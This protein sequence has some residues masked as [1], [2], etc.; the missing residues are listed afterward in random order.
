MS[1]DDPESRESKSP[2]RQKH[3]PIQHIGLKVLSQPENAEVDIV[4]VHGI[5]AHPEKTWVSK[6]SNVN[7]LSHKT[8]L[9]DAIPNARI[10]AFGYASNWFGDGAVKLTL[11]GVARELLM[12]LGSARD[13]CKHRPIVFI[14]HCFGGLVIQQAYT[15]AALH[16][17]DENLF[18]IFDSVTGMVFLGTP[19]YGVHENF[20]RQMWEQI[21]IKTNEENLQVQDNILHSLTSGN[22]L[23]AKCVLDFTR[24][25]ALEQQRAPRLFCFYEQ[26]PSR[27]DLIFGLPNIIQEFI[28]NGSSGI[29]QGHP[30]ECLP[31][32]HFNLNKFKSNADDS[33]IS[34]CRE[35]M[36][37]VKGSESIMIS[38]KIARTS[39][40]EINERENDGFLT[41]E[42]LSYSY[43]K[44]TIYARKKRTCLLR[45]KA[46]HQRVYPGSPTV[47][48]GPKSGFI[49]PLAIGPLAQ[50]TS[51]IEPA[52][53]V[54]RRQVMI[55]KII[56]GLGRKASVMR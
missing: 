4:A 13:G 23:L 10:M 29:L 15:I 28:V 22:D 7:W 42:T 33:Y 40:G 2:K 47:S 27:I 49:R 45:Y 32:D 41:R 51:Y 21:H 35:I 46:S 30:C 18:G 37:M 9:P 1:L 24:T 3:R 38:R 14:G 5:G 39:H 50:N 11:D 55:L 8:M 25:V 44:K 43:Q 31:L 26:K 34:V 56:A 53:R 16:H 48:H 20:Q 52:T 36:K 17:K 54:K 6:E 19:H 12:A